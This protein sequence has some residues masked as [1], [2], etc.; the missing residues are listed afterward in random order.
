[1][2]ALTKAGLPRSREAGFHTSRTYKRES[3]MLTTGSQNNVC[4]PFITVVISPLHSKSPRLGYQSVSDTGVSPRLSA[5]SSS[6]FAS[7]VGHDSL[8][9][10]EFRVYGVHFVYSKIPGRVERAIHTER[11]YAGVCGLCQCFTYGKDCLTQAAIK[12]LVKLY[13]CRFLPR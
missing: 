9:S 6:S 3:T 13:Q 5:R 12:G 1:M 10:F 4:H 8:F 11:G 2:R 7:I